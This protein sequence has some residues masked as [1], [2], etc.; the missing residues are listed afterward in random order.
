MNIK[1]QEIDNALKY[2]SINDDEYRNK[3][4]KCI[5]D[6][7]TIEEFNKKVEEIYNILYIDKTFKIDTLWQRQDMRELFGEAYN[8]YVT[9]VLI[10]LGYNLHKNNMEDVAYSN[11]QKAFYK[12]RVKESLT[13]DIYIRKLD[14]IRISQMIWAAYFINIKLIEVGRLQYEKCQDHIKIHIPAGSK[15]ELEQVKDSVEKSREKIKKYFKMENQEYHCDSWLL[16]NQ[17]NEII[18]D[19]SNI[20]KFYRLFEVRDGADATKD[21]LKYVFNVLEC[22]DYN[23]LIE[24][25]TL[26]KILKKELINNNVFKSGYGILKNH[27]N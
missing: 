19:N 21:I 1:K 5:D 13:D 25:T 24:N 2:Y 15:L 10:L 20:A 11:E 7:N 23:N 6:I 3:C 16:S 27:R 26:Q 9:N 17:L 14:G 12:N 4:Y 22:T 18:E 8:P